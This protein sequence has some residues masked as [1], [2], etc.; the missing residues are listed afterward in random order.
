MNET[1]R[2][3]GIID[4]DTGNIIFVSRDE[5]Y[6]QLEES[7]KRKTVK[8]PVDLVKQIKKIKKEKDA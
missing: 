4:T 8:L 3:I 2:K 5:G 7:A 6:R 1:E